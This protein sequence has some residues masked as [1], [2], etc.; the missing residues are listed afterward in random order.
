[1]ER[2]E[3]FPSVVPASIGRLI[4]RSEIQSFYLAQLLQ[5]LNHSTLMWR[6]TTSTC[7]KQLF[8]K[9]GLKIPRV[10]YV[11]NC[12]ETFLPLNVTKERAVRI[13]NVFPISPRGLQSISP[14]SAEQQPLELL[15][16]NIP[17]SVSRWGLIPVWL[18]RWLYLCKEMNLGGQRAISSSNG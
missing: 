3:D 14:C 12:D 7:S 10:S 1:M 6:R 11:L 4:S 16:D 8:M 5:E 17:E 9:T 2:H 15:D 13:L 18:I